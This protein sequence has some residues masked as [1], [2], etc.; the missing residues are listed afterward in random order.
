MKSLFEKEERE[1]AIKELKISLISRFYPFSKEE[2]IKYQD[3]LNFSY[4]NFMSNVH[5]NWDIDLIE[6]LKDKIDWSGITR[7]KSIEFDDSFLKTYKGYISIDSIPYMNNIQW[8][9]SIISE[10]GD[11]FDWSSS[12]ILKKGITSIDN[13]R[14][15]K[16]QVNWSNLSEHI[17]LVKDENVISEFDEFWDWKKLSRN[18]HLPISLTFILK[19]LNKLDFDELSSNPNCLDLIYEYPTSKKW[20]WQRVIKNPGIIYNRE[21]YAFMIYFYQKQFLEPKIRKPIN[22]TFVLQN[23]IKD[24]F[25]APYLDKSYFL[26]EEF[27]PYIP[28]KVMH[29]FCD[30]KFDLDFI[31]K[32]KDKFDFS[33]D[34]FIRKHK[35][36]LTEEFILK[37]LN[38]FNPKAY[39]FYSLPI[40]IAIIKNININV[41]WNSLSSCKTLDWNW[42]FFES[43]FD[44]LNL[45][46]LSE[47]E[48]FYEKVIKKESVLNELLESLL[49]K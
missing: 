49:P 31:E 16:N 39:T 33:N 32:H 43:N 17:N 9:D 46:R 48:G 47:N 37:N 22:K 44:K 35:T 23:F 12:Y 26:K 41:N 30:F 34:D 15:Y 25:Y 29:T 14:K 8:N 27:N 6:K 45:F 21:S 38:L 42:D 13:L 10:Y 40:S 11:K 24:I 36:I 7:I 1:N 20:N 4:G 19:N 5:I 3:S 18:R 2:V 28:F